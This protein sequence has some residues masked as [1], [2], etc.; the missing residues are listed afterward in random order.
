[1]AIKGGKIKS[2]NTGVTVYVGSFLTLHN[3]LVLVETDWMRPLG[4]RIHSQ[5]WNTMNKKLCIKSHEKLVGI[6][7]HCN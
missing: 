7:S 6:H 5:S 3:I 2:G 1:M 4:Q